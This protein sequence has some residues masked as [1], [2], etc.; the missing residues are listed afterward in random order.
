MGLS[1]E[2][3]AEKPYPD[4]WS[5]KEILGHLIDSAS[6]NHQ[7]IVRMQE[8]PD[9]GK[10]GYEQLH[11]VNSQS[12]QTEP[13]SDI[14][15]LWTSYNIHLAHVVEH[16]DSGSLANVCDIDYPKLATL[17]YVIN[18]YVRHMRHHLGQIFSG[19]DPR[20]RAEWKEGS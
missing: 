9:I 13:W 11:W 12:Y 20:K 2:H 18:D 17:E 14:V 8:H 3:V 10:L 4:K 16:V 19:A 15:N 6:T 7:R 5:L 1:E